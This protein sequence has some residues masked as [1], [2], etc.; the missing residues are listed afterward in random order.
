MSMTGHDWGVWFSKNKSM[1]KNLLVLAVFFFVLAKMIF[2]S[3]TYAPEATVGVALGVALAFKVALDK[4]D[5]FTSNV[6]P[7]VPVVPEVTPVIPIIVEPEKFDYPISQSKISLREVNDIFL[8]IGLP[9]NMINLSDEYFNLCSVSDASKFT[10]ETKVKAGVWT[11]NDHDCDNFSFALLGY[12]SDG[13][14]SYAFGYAR[15]LTHAFNVMIDDQKKLWICEP[16]TNQWYEYSG[17]RDPMYRI[18]EVMM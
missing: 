9:E 1:I 10:E 11:Q 3:T 5:F 15:S 7:P 13:L 12:W 17:M 8:S 16:Q 4:L 2:S 18:I 6:N 14:I